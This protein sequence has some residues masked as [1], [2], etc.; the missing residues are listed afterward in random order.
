MV[1]YVDQVDQHMPTLT[2][3][4]TMEFAC[5]MQTG[6]RKMEM[7]GKTGISEA[8]FGGTGNAYQL[9][10]DVLLHLL[11]LYRCKDTIIGNAALRGVSGGERKRVTTGEML[12]GETKA[13]MLDEIST[14]GVTWCDVT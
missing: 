10:I 1:S 11:G 8:D 5:H 7:H 3:R 14:V 4:E 6:Y 13:F 12:M 9:K 2:V